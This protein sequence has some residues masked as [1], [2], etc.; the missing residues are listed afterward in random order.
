MKRSLHVGLAR[1]NPQAYSGWNGELVGPPLDL[2]SMVMLCAQHGFEATGLLTDQATRTNLLEGIRNAAEQLQEGDVFLLHY[3]GHGGQEQDPIGVSPA[4]R[5]ET[6]CLYDGELTE[7]ELRTALSAFRPGVRVYVISDSCHSGGLAKASPG[8]MIVANARKGKVK[9]MPQAARKQPLYVSSLPKANLRAPALIFAACQPNEV[10]WDTENGGAFTTNLLT[11]MLE[12][13]QL[14]WAQLC[15]KT[16]QY[17]ADWGYDQHPRID[18]IG[19]GAEG[20]EN[21]QAFG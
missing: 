15:A 18:L 12:N 5:I 11:A 17:I 21:F 8:Q 7:R 6:L 4:S 10:S 14:T 1:V 20:L 13:P 19:P 9:A 2:G 3:S 16:T